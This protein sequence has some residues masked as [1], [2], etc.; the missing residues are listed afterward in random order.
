MA[1]NTVL[2]DRIFAGEGFT[3]DVLRIAGANALLALS[4]H[5]AIPLPWTPVPVTGQTF[6]VLL[7]GAL[8]GARRAMIAVVFYL[9]E[10]MAGLPVFQPYGMPGA[11]R[12]WGPTAGYLLAYPP[13]AFATGWLLESS[14]ADSVLGLVAALSCGEG[15]I[16]LGGCGWLALGLGRGWI[17][18]LG[19]GAIPFLPGE[20]L[21]MALIVA[22]VRG[23]ESLR[24]KST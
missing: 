24:R 15:L 7:V 2:A 5:I 14:A 17:Y 12:F 10:G 3:A 23:A 19:A 21:K 18:A 13:A 1:Q 20:V 6:G 9:L 22:I 4:A 8:L 16:F 11:A